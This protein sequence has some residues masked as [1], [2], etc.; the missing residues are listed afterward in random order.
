MLYLF[1]SCMDRTIFLFL[2]VLFMAWDFFPVKSHII[3]FMGICHV[4][5]FGFLNLSSFKL[6]QFFFKKHFELSYNLCIATINIAI[7]NRA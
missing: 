6:L 3:E 7:Q 4:G 1:T 5:H 2:T